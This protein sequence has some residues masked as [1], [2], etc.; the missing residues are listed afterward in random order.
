MDKLWV[1][2]TLFKC[3]CGKELM[4]ALGMHS[5]KLM[6]ASQGIFMLVSVTNM[7]I[8]STPELSSAKRN[9]LP[10]AVSFILPRNVLVLLVE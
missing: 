2:L 10:D 9:D 1:L 7:T 6:S 5:W 3:M 8:L 4:R